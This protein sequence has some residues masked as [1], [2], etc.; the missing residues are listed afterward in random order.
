MGIVHSI[1]RCVYSFVTRHQLMF[2]IFPIMMPIMQ[3]FA[4]PS[5][6]ANARI[7]DKNGHSFPVVKLNGRYF[8]AFGEDRIRTIPD[9][10]IR[11]GDVILCGYPKT[12]CHWVHEILHMLV[13][14]KAE[15]T[16]HGKGMG[17]IDFMPDIMID[18]LASPRVLNTHVLYDELPRGIRQ[19]KNKIVLTVRN[20]KDSVVS[21]FNH[22]KDLK[23]FYGYEGD[24]DGLFDL[25]MGPV[26]E[27]GNY[28]DFYLSWDQILKSPE[29][30][31][32]LLVR[33][34]D[35]KAEP[36]ACVKRIAEFLELKVTDEFAAEVV[37][38]TSL[39]KMK[40]KREGQ[41]GA[42]LLR[43][44]VVGGWRNWLTDEQSQRMD[45]E[46]NDKMSSLSHQ[47]VY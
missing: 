27:Y 41:M 32:I 8:P 2:Y 11:E 19:K 29:K 5:K 35:N 43:K 1:R 34:E 20:P 26:M 14:G 13:N 28:F 36:V 22:I 44:G 40:E 15:L 21:Y 9:I 25:F 33:Y 18:S 3:K 46:W 4:D 31:P 12:G 39:K 16:S 17:M 30:H 23:K 7:T 45:K 10:S 47:P 38:K 24:F 42:E 37:E 6:K